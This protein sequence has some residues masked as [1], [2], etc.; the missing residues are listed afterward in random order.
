MSGWRL[1][2]SRRCNS[3]TNSATRKCQLIVSAMGR[4]LALRGIKAAFHNPSIVGLSLASTMAVLLLLLLPLAYAQF[5]STLGVHPTGVSYSN[6]SPQ[7]LHGY[8]HGAVHHGFGKREAEP[9]Y[10][11]HGYGL[12]AAHHPVHHAIGYGVYHHGYGKRSPTHRNKPRRKMPKNRSYRPRYYYYRYYPG[13]TTVPGIITTVE[14]A[15]RLQTPSTSAQPGK[16][17]SW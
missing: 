12:V 4:R 10:A 17:S 8:H 11:G 14:E 2:L 7:G 16:I 13:I 3:L 1:N 15:K 5:H 9:Y 6:R